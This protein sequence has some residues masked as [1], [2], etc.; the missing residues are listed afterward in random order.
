[1]PIAAVVRQAAHLDLDLVGVPL[2][3]GGIGGGYA[4]RAAAALNLVRRAYTCVPN[5]QVAFGD[6]HLA[7]IKAWR[8]EHLPAALGVPALTYPL[9]NESYDVLAADLEQSGVPCIIS[10]VGADAAGASE[11]VRGLAVGET[12]FSRVFMAR[13]AAAGCDA[14]GE[15]GEFH[16]LAHVWAVPRERALGLDLEV[17]LEGGGEAA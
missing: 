6:L 14:F 13:A 12:R 1:M 11:F 8:D 15:R 7:H 4:R 2:M 16:T 3:R 10:A 9:W 17:D 5:L